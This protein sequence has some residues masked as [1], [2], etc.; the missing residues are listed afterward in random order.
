MNLETHKAV[1]EKWRARPIHATSTFVSDGPIDPNRWL[2][3]EPRVLFLMKE[4]YGDTGPGETWDLPE[5]IREDWKGPKYKLW[6]TL[7]YWAY[8]IQR[9][10]NGPIPSNPWDDQRWEQ[11]RESVLGSAV[12]NIK[13][14]RGRS[15]SNNDD[16][17]RYVFKDGDLLKRQVKCLSPHVMVCCSTWNLVKDLW[18]QTEEISERVYRIDGMQVLNFWH[19]ANRYPDVMNYYTLAVLLHRAMF[20]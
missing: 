20:P 5:L 11:V 16:L 9:L 6:W 7:G 15:Q 12:V 14:S 1:L 2:K 10:T 17:R 18:P 8:G 19:P 3:I 13:K 4:A